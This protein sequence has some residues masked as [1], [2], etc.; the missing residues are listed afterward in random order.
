VFPLRRLEGAALRSFSVALLLTLS[1]SA[2]RAEYVV[3]RSGARLTVTG[4]ELIGD[5][6]KLQMNGGTAEIL[7]AEVVGIEP[8]E[9]FDPL[10]EPLSANTPFDEIIRAAA[11]RYGVDPDLI[12]SVIAV[13]SNFNP[14]AVSRRN[15]R[16][17]M[18]LLPNTAARLGVKNIFD[19]KENVDGGTRYLRDMLARYN[20]DVA[21]ALAA[22]NAGP[23]SVEK[24]GKRIPPYPETRQ[25]IDRIARTYA[26]SKRGT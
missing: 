15:A 5:R 14:K 21:L 8:Q 25:Y 18:Q 22:Y 24:Y 1:V 12:H 20:N 17:L 10:P 16:G 13:E 4:Y 9:I 19:P 3:L 7:A 2:A 11:D 23:E 26:K 6:Y